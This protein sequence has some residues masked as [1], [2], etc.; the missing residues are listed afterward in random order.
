[1]DW[2]IKYKKSLVV[3][4]LLSAVMA[5]AFILYLRDKGTI[6]NIEK[7]QLGLFVLPWVIFATSF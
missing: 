1:M 6:E 2:I 5:V 7:W 3:T 4:A